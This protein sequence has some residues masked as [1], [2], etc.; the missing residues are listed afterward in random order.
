MGVAERELPS[1]RTW[2][3]GL[4]LATAFVA[5]IVWAVAQDANDGEVDTADDEELDEGYDG[6]TPPSVVDLD[7]G[8]LHLPPPRPTTELPEYTL[9]VHTDGC[10]V[11]RTPSGGAPDLTWVVKDADGFQVLGRVAENEDRYRYFRPGSY[12]VVLESYGVDV[13]N[14]VS[15]TC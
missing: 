6:I 15:I 1:R 5:T 12:T 2:I 3:L 4:V 11:I 8:P 10:G 9:T 7:P 14:T 13:S